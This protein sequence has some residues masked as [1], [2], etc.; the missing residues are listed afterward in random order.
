MTKK[1]YIE[2]LKAS[3]RNYPY[4]FQTD[5]LETFENH[6]QE[7]IKQGKSEEEIMNDL[8]SVEE[9]LENIRSMNKEEKK[10]ENSFEDDINELSNS[11]KSA[12]DSFGKIASNVAKNA[13][14]YFESKNK[15]N[16]HFNVNQ[17]NENGIIEDEV[18]EIE[19]SGK[20][21][22][23]GVDIELI[24]GDEFKYEFYYKE[25][26][27]LQ[28]K[29]PI[30]ILS[31]KE[32]TIFQIGKNGGNLIV[33]IPSFIKMVKVNIS[34]GDISLSKLILNEVSLHSSLGDIKI[35]HGTIDYVHINL[36]SGDV[37]I[38]GLNNDE[39]DIHTGAGD[40]EISDYKGKINA[41]SNA[42]DISIKNSEVDRNATISTSAGDVYYSGKLIEGNIDSKAGD[43]DLEIL[44]EFKLINVKTTTGDIDC[45]VYYDD[46]VA[47][48]STALGDIDVDVD[49][50]PVTRINK[51][52]YVIGNGKGQLFLSTSMGD[53]DLH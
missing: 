16:F 21:L 47:K 4:E 46:Y 39:A 40:I 11:L 3:L 25:N 1:E 52:E 43:I 49:G 35:N 50:V 9:V 17:K 7:G 33:Y 12:F 27:F 20:G 14:E 13:S 38:N 10:T 26:V 8:G 29:E 30:D 53:I 22:L 31:G 37:T 6:F 48:L 24:A 18:S 34:N 23:S 5:I 51:K 28:Q 45:H 42:G 36:T 19:I 44:D 41:T 2:T 32:K 15:D